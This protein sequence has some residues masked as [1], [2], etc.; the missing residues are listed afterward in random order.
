[1]IKKIITKLKYYW[2]KIK[3]IFKPIPVMTKKDIFMGLYEH[4]KVNHS[5][6]LN[7]QC[8][9]GCFLNH[10]NIEMQ[11]CKDF[12]WIIHDCPKCR[13]RNQRRYDYT[14]NRLK[15]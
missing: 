9:C 5:N 12:I 14:W 8:L 11:F 13:M 1:M 2:K 10:E 3:D 4:I 15:D 6:E 7:M